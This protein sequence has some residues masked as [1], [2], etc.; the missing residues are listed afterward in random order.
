MSRLLKKRESSDTHTDLAKISF[1]YPPYKKAWNHAGSGLFLF[2]F[3]QRF[4]GF[5]SFFYHPYSVACGGFNAFS[6][7][8]AMSSLEFLSTWAQ[9]LLHLDNGEAHVQKIAGRA[10]TEVMQAYVRQATFGDDVVEG[11]G[12]IVG[13]Y[14]VPIGPSTHI[15]ALYIPCAQSPFQALLV[16]FL[17]L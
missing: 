5:L 6:M 17:G 15:A 8:A 7:A 16:A 12:Q 2:S 10:V 9:P 4:G 1:S 3:Y 11:A 14:H 13:R